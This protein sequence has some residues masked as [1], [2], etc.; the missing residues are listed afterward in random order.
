MR[1]ISSPSS[2]QQ[3]QG[4]GPLAEFNKPPSMFNSTLPALHSFM[5]LKPLAPVPHHSTQ[6]AFQL[7]P[8]FRQCETPSP[9]TNLNGVS[10]SRSRSRAPSTGPG[11]MRT[12]PTT[13]AKRNSILSASPPRQH[14]SA[15]FITGANGSIRA[16]SQRVAH[17]PLSLNT[18]S[19]WFAP[20]FELPT[21][22]SVTSHAGAFGLHGRDSSLGPVVDEPSPSAS[23]MSDVAAKQ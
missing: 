13:L 9:V 11:P 1:L 22:D 17:S 3:Q 12:Q 23:G 4:A 18:A 16:P 7:P 15:I 6:V 20:E 2:F 10:R 14:P 5:R 19:G 21:P 8:D